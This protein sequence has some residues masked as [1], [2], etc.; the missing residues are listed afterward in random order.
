MDMHMLML[1]GAG[2]LVGIG[3]SFSGLGGGFLI[4]PLL[5][6]LGYNAQRAV[7]T[8]FVAILV[9][10]LSAVFAHN[11]LANVDIRTGIL[12]GLGGVIG[13][14]IGPRLLSGVSTGNFRKIFAM[15]LL[16]LAAYVFFRK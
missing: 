13:A 3:A 9:I 10:S 8:A 15:V 6:Y 4:V 14:Q 16:G 7:G 2:T 11:K 12:L 1:V 5:L